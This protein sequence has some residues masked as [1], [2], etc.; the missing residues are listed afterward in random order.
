MNAPRSPSCP[1]A[2]PAGTPV[3]LPGSANTPML[4]PS[5]PAGVGMLWLIFAFT[6]PSVARNGGAAQ[7]PLGS[8]GRSP[9]S[10]SCRP[11]AG[12]PWISWVGTAGRK[13]AQ[14]ESRARGQAR[15]NKDRQAFEAKACS[16]S[17]TWNS[18]SPGDNRPPPHGPVRLSREQIR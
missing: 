2:R 1:C 16:A 4:G 9:T 11:A 8:P 7:A 12:Q 13:L 15:L 3:A 18:G 6:G 17:R 14:Y 5:S 10:A